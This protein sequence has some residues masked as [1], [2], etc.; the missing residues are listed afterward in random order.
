MIRLQELIHKFEVGEGTRHVRTFAAILVLLA[1]A[2]IYDVREYRNFSTTEAMDTAQ[3]A[4]NIAE[5]RGYTTLFVRPLSISL[6]ESRQ[7]QLGRRTN[8]FAL[9]KSGHPDLANP[10]LYPLILAGLMKVLPFDYQITDRDVARGLMLFRY[11]PEEL[12][13]FFNEALFLVVIFLVFRLARRLFD[14][15]V[16]WISAVMIAGSDL[17]WRFSVSGL[18]TVLLMVIFLSVVWCLVFMEEASRNSQRGGAWFAAIALV[19]G[20]LLGLGALTR[21]SFGWLILPVLAF[22]ALYLSRRRV[23]LCLVVF[24]AFV[25]VLAP[26]LAR[27]HAWSGTLFG[28]AGY[29]A[30]EGTAAFPSDQLERSL[31]PDF[32]IVAFN[33]FFR[34]L[35]VNTSG[36]LQDELPKLGGN[37]ISAFFLV[38]LLVP[39]V[40]KALGRVRIFL[41]LSLVVVTVAQAMGKT[42]LSEASSEINSENL[43]VLLAPLVFIYGAG[44]YSML[45]D[46]LN[47]PFPQLRHVVTGVVV[48][49]VSSPLIL[50]LLPPREFPLAFPP[51]SPPWIQQ[52]GRWMEEKELVMSDMPWAMAW[53]G[54]RQS[55]WTTLSVRDDQ[56]RDDFFSINDSRKPIRALYLTTL[57]MDARFHSQIIKGKP[58]T[59]E[60]F[61][62]DGLVTTNGLPVGF[63]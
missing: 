59:W 58:G 62:L 25:A 21:Y 51:Y 20:G 22:V 53:Y 1:L 11:Q 7:M 6:V 5:G 63:P 15:S 33:D 57:S 8:D 26:W 52:F 54:R 9:L 28:T 61:L 30:V 4:R 24:A 49:L 19:V 18:S 46:Q 3:L 37:W 45:L 32:G 31:K 44:M 55:V 14:T 16:A 13:S 60:R 41:V 29:A 47:L 27:N 35:A 17:F 40:S 23:V 12:I 2:T 38:G 36:I 42:H 48:V 34:K 10:P 39:F 50:T 56:R 43:L